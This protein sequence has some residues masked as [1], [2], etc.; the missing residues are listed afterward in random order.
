[1][2]S[3][4]CGHCEKLFEYREQIVALRE[5]DGGVVA[6]RETELEAGTV[7]GAF[8]PV[9]KFHVRCYETMRSEAPDDW[10]VPSFN[11]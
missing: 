11:A 5:T 4:R 10:P 7:E 2:P 3:L 1:M 9:G 6:E 8:E